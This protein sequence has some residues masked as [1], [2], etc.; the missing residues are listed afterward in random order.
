MDNNCV[1][2]RQEKKVSSNIKVD[3]VL[4]QPMR[5][6]IV[7][8]REFAVKRKKRPGRARKPVRAPKL[9][10]SSSSYK[11][12]TDPSDDNDV[13]LFQA[14]SFKSLL[15]AASVE[16]LDDDDDDDDDDCADKK[17]AGDA[18]EEDDY[19]TAKSHKENPPQC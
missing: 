1:E 14:A 3:N 11:D 19:A 8:S 4:E 6:K 18:D 5:T 7:L 2:Q 9:H 12:E 17:E 10:K 16:D 15:F 13:K